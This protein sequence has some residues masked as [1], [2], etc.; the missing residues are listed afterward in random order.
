MW[1]SMR[2]QLRG[3][4]IPNVRHNINSFRMLSHLPFINATNESNNINGTLALRKSKQN[5]WKGNIIFHE[6]TIVCIQ[7]FSTKHH[8]VSGK[9]EFT[10]KK[11]YLQN[12]NIHDNELNIMIQNYNHLQEQLNSLD[13]NGEEVVRIQFKIYK[14]LRSI[15]NHHWDKS[16]TLLS[17]EASE[18]ALECLLSLKALLSSSSTHNSILLDMEDEI[19][20]DLATL[21]HFIGNIYTKLSLENNGN[22]H[23]VNIE[24]EAKKTSMNTLSRLE[25]KKEALKWFKESLDLKQKI[26][27]SQHEEV[28]KTMNGMGM[29][30][31]PSSP[32]AELR[33]NDLT[34]SDSTFSTESLKLENDDRQD[35]SEDFETARN[36][37][38]VSLNI[39]RNTYSDDHPFVA[40]VRENLGRV[41]MTSGFYKDAL[42]EFE[43]VLR[44]KQF[45]IDNG[46][47]DP[48]DDSMA[49]LYS[50]MGDCLFDINEDLKQPLT[51]YNNA[52]N[53]L[54]GKVE[55]KDDIQGQA[56]EMY[57][58]L[59]TL[60]HKLGL[61][62]SRMSKLDMA[63]A[64]FEESIMMKKLIG[65]DDHFEVGITLNCMGALYGTKGDKGKALSFFREALR[66]FKKHAIT[67]DGVLDDQNVNVLNALSN[68]ALLERSSTN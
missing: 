54:K 48:N 27:G 16:S 57:L 38:Q 39:F 41:Y 55:M 18:D 58:L 34:K 64:Q 17:K 61:V 11:Q 56:G 13:R 40:S 28:A 21:L 62:Y 24:S 68:I 29:L 14:L 23:M 42:L 30:Y 15:G 36:L 51:M 46:G 53:I 66:I 19:K 6:R 22:S 8:N 44:I 1:Q 37:F 49:S 60:Y 10:N 5:K 31:A 35:F 33:E 3:N 52:M 12:T 45:Y 50:V 63:L 9:N 25:Y 47:F 59:A 20:K 2:R 32:L 67:E 4:N 26:F 7:T 65:G 43:E